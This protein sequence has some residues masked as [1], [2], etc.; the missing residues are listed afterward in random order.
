MWESKPRSLFLPLV[1]YAAPGKRTARKS[2]RSSGPCLIWRWSPSLA[3]WPFR[4]FGHGWQGR[5]AQNKICGTFSS[6]LSP[7]GPLLSF[8]KTRLA[9]KSLWCGLCVPAARTAAVQICHLSKSSWFTRL[10]VT[11]EADVYAV[12]YY[13]TESHVAL[14]LLFFRVLFSKFRTTCYRMMYVHMLARIVAF[15]K[16]F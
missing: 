6:L 9:A 4:G 14:S 1:T 15:K 10:S 12:A 8:P 16:Y 2:R 5:K 13:H 7:S 11:P 3:R